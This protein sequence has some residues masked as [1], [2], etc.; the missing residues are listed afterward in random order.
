MKNLINALEVAKE[1]LWR[2]ENNFN[3]AES[4]YIDTAIHS[5]NAARS[6]Y[7]ALLR[8]LKYSTQTQ[9]GKLGVA[10]SSCNS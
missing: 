8:E 2:A 3:N 1:E 10:F 7:G 9:G 5:L 4:E 6:K